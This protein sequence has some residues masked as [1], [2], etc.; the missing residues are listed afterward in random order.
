MSVNDDFVGLMSENDDSAHV[1]HVLERKFQSTD[2]RQIL[3]LSQQLHSFKM[4]EEVSIT[5]YIQKAREL[6]N[7]LSLMGEV[8]LDKTKALIVLN[9]LTQSYE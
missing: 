5:H 2:Q 6:K 9:G 8:V 4:M 1:W 7:K 3:L